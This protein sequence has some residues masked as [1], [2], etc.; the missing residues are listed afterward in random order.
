MKR[1]LTSF[2]YIAIG[3]GT[4]VAAVT[5][6]EL[7]TEIT[8]GGGERRGGSDVTGSRTTTTVTNDTSQ[9]ETTFTFTSSFAVTECGLFNASSNGTM[10]C[11]QIFSAI[12]VASGDTITFTW[13]IQV[14]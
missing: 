5:Q 3:T 8:T 11:R 13:K 2:D 4:T 12:N 14:A 10:L 1:S 7:V 9:W 6:T